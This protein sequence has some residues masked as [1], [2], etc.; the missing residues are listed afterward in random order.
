MRLLAG[1]LYLGLAAF[2]GSERHLLQIT[3]GSIM[4]IEHT[5]FDLAK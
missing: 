2:F 5:E 4:G 3:S 1:Q